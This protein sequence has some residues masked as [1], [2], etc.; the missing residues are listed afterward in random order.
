MVQIQGAAIM[1]DTSHSVFSPLV[2]ASF[3]RPI[4]DAIHN[5][6]HPGI[7]ATRRLIAS[8]FVGPCLA[9]E[10]A[11]WCR[12]CQ[13]CQRAKVTKQPAPAPQAIANPV[14]RFSRLHID[15][16]GP[17]PQSNSGYTHLLMVL[18]RSS[19]WG[20]ALPLRSTSAE[21]CATTLIAGWVARFGVPQQITS[22]RGSQFCSSVSD[23]FTRR[24]GIKSCLT[25]PYYPQSN[26]AVERF[27]HRL[28]DAL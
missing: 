17:L 18:D 11:T 24:L 16:V 23:S 21:S 12:D 5:L 2:P 4:F 3:R 14:Q 27:H 10:V 13:Q 15:L 25:T 22:D 26:G 20:E 1:V 28:K 9:S 6:A 7:R 19:R 8:C